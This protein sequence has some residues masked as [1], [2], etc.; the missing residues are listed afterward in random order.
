[1]IMSKAEHTPTLYRDAH[2][3]CCLLEI[4][5]T[6]ESRDGEWRGSPSGHA[7]GFRDH[8]RRA[9]AARP[10]TLWLR[11]QPRVVPGGNREL[12][13]RG[14]PRAQPRVRRH[15]LL[16]SRAAPVLRRQAG[17]ASAIRPP[18]ACSCSTGEGEEKCPPSAC[19]YSTGEE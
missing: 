2:S 18:S 7:H 10:G 15:R 8:R 6:G 1:M 11:A 16:P 12:C 9:P 3:S 19:S 17:A 14:V 4:P 13:G 5:T